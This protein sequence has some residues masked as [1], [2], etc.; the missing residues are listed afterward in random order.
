[1]ARL[2][3]PLFVK[4]TV[5]INMKWEPNSHLDYFQLLRAIIFFF[6][7][8]ETELWD[9]VPWTVHP[10]PRPVKLVLSINMLILQC[11]C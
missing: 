11:L 1:M 2:F 3:F 6:V 5:L 4:Q 10:S 9:D 8:D 7:I